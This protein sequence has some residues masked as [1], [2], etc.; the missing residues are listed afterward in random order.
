LREVLAEEGKALKSNLEKIEKINFALSEDNIGTIK[1]G[2]QIVSE[3]FYVL[4][5][6]LSPEDLLLETMKRLQESLLAEDFYNRIISITHDLEEI[7]K[8]YKNWYMEIHSKRKEAYHELSE[9]V[10][11]LT[12][13]N[14][15]PE[16]IKNNILQEI[17]LKSCDNLDI[18]ESFICSN[19]RATISQMESD[20]SAKDGI[21]KHIQQV[22]DNFIT[23]TDESIEKIKFSDFF[24]KNVSTPEEFKEQADKFIKHIEDLLKEGKKI[25]LE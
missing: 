5:N 20:I 1:K 10:K 18:Q 2:K 13:W 11:G 6:K 8:F 24:A 14:S 4:K 22:I 3:L 7:V 17:S 21:K 19:C 9:T 25:I 23:K 15:L 16:E 12:E